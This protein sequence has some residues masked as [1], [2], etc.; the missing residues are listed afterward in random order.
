MHKNEQKKNSHEF[1]GHCTIVHPE[2]NMCELINIVLYSNSEWK[3]SFNRIKW[4]IHDNKRKKKLDWVTYV[5]ERDVTKSVIIIYLQG[6]KWNKRDNAWKIEP[7]TL[8]IR[9][10]L[11]GLIPWGIFTYFLSHIC[12]CV[13]KNAHVCI[14]KYVWMHNNSILKI[15]W[16]F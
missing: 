10:N 7:F 4:L 14:I 5:I 8:L 11:K 15:I 1:Y 13:H 2:Q 9:T 12:M 6:N 16:D 3:N